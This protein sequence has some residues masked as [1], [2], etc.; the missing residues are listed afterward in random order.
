MK[1]QLKKVYIFSTKVTAAG[2]EIGWDFVTMVMK[3]K[4]FFTAFCTET[5]KKY[6]TN[7]INAPNFMSANTFVKRFFGWLAHMKIDFRKEIN[8]WCGHDPQY[9]AC[10][11]T[12]I[13]VNIKHMHLDRPVIFPDKDCEPLQALHRRKDRNIIPDDET[14]KHLWYIC[15]QVLPKA[16]TKQDTT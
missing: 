14:R 11:G 13:G 9:L 15:E 2:D 12:H 1:L 3:T 16:K 6:S 7:S 5:S 4:T 8:P 10:D